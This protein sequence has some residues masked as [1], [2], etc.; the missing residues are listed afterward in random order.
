MWILHGGIS[1]C[2]CPVKFAVLD[3]IDELQ[4]DYEK[5]SSTCDDFFWVLAFEVHAILNMLWS[6]ATLKASENQINHYY[7]GITIYG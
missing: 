7:V 6:Q 2:I 5:R 1:I 4:T 3:I